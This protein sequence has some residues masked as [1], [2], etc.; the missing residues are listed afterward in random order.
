M[1]LGAWGFG[2]KL[3]FQARSNVDV[4]FYSLLI[5]MEYEPGEWLD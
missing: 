4:K 1:S 2:G 5:L 3:A